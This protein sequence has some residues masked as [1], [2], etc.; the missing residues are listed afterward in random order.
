MPD[1]GTLRKEIAYAL[2]TGAGFSKLDSEYNEALSD[3]EKYSVAVSY[4]NKIGILKGYP[5]GTLGEEKEVTR[6]EFATLIKRVNDELKKENEGVENENTNVSGYPRPHTFF[7]VV[8]DVMTALSEQGEPTQKICGYINGEYEE[9]FI[10][11]DVEISNRLGVADKIEVN[12]ILYIFKDYFGK[13]MY[14]TVL[15]D[16]DFL[17][18]VNSYYEFNIYT[19][20]KYAFGK[21][22]K[23][24]NGNLIEIIENEAHEITEAY[25]VKEDAAVYILEDDEIKLSK[26]SKIRENYIK[27]EGDFIFS[28][29][30]DDEI[31]DILIIR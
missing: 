26:L 17:K 15:E 9:N 24:R 21:V 30:Y 22:E 5:D 20:Y 4:L 10:Y 11:D 25:R 31:T 1:A 19:K 2:Y 6:A 3:S 18:N 7:Y 13:I 12:D 28:L 27:D 14:V 8:T 29:A 23:I 16:A